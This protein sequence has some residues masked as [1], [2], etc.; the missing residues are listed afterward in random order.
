MET[1]NMESLQ[2]FLMGE[3][4][5]CGLLGRALYEDPDHAWLDQL[6]REDVFSEVPL[7]AGQEDVERGRKMLDQWAKKYQKGLPKAELDAIQSDRL[8]LFIGVGKPLAPV[9]ESV[10]FNE[11]RLIFQ[12]QTLQVRN[13]YT[14]FGLQFE[15][16]GNEP[17]DHM[18]V[19]LLFVGHLATLAFKALEQGDGASADAL[20]QNQ[21]DFLTEHLLRWAP[22]WS[23]L[24]EKH[25]H[26]DFFQGLAILTRGALMTI[27]QVL[28]IEIPQE[29]G[30]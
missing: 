10:Y 29:E 1:I 6:I 3:A 17:D 14:R 22:A 9:W 15:H 12:E 11:G 25:A 16:L 21:R 4:L 30:K 18:G 5:L 23:G 8:Y 13:W 2:S 26:T 28:K 7:G 20:L 27:S 19:E 24:V